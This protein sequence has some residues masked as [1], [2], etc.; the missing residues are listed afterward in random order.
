[1]WSKGHQRESTLDRDARLSE[2][3]F[4]A[5]KTI[6]TTAPS[7]MPGSSSS[8]ESA[9]SQCRPNSLTPGAVC[10]A[11]ISVCGIMTGMGRCGDRSRSQCFNYNGLLLVPTNDLLPVVLE[12]P[13][14]LSLPVLCKCQK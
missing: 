12:H 11:V 1:M 4:N 6:F 14:P 9:P 8:G 7:L 10:G 5:T 3:Q 2:F 13:H